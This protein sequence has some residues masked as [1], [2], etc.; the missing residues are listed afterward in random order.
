MLFAHSSITSDD[1]GIAHHTPSPLY[2]TSCCR[3]RTAR[4]VLLRF[5]RLAS[6]QLGGMRARAN[7]GLEIHAGFLQPASPMLN[8]F[9]SEM[10]CVYLC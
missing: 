9:F 4:R 3:S 6:E 1:V 7:L 8:M 2:H 10:R 5:F